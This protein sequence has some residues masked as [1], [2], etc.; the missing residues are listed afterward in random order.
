MREKIRE[1]NIE[2]I[3][4]WLVIKLL[5]GEGEKLRVIKLKLEGEMKWIEL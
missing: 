4:I 3:G 1:L 2:W 5:W